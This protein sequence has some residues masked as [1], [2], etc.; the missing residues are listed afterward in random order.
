MGKLIYDVSMSL[1]G[2][3]TGANPRVEAGWGGLGEGGEQLHAWGFKDDPDPRN[4]EIMEAFA[5]FGA[6]IFG[7]TTYDLSILNWGAD[8]PTGAARIPTVIV[9]HSV[10]QDVPEGGVY[11][12]VNGVEAAFEKAKTLAGDKDI[13]TTGSNVAKQLLKLGLIDEIAI[14]LVPVLFGSGTRLF[15]GLDSVVRGA[16]SHIPLESVET[17]ETADVI[18]LRFR[19]VK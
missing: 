15:E 7:R 19:V 12:F 18:H 13:S 3:I 10:P 6:T 17:I 9:S 5:D 8:G 2:F 1:D 4:V 11:H 16:N 14:H